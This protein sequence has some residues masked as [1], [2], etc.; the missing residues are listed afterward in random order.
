MC[1]VLVRQE[2]V[3]QDIALT[4]LDRYGPAP[5][6]VSQTLEEAMA[7][8]AG[9]ARVHAAV[10]ELGPDEV[11]GSEIEREIVARGGHIVLFGKN[12]EAGAGCSRWPVLHRPFLDNTLLGLLNR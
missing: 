4:L 8:V 6:C 2:L 3:A 10:L 1:V 5:V 12:A 9:A 7:H 11:E